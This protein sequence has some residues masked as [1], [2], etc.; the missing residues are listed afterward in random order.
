MKDIS[1]FVMQ[2]VS[3]MMINVVLIYKKKRKTQNINGQELP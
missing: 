3:G 1:G 2:Q